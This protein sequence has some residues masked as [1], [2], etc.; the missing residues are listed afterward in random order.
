[1]RLFVAVPAAEGFLEEASLA[2]SLL[3]TAGADVKWVNP[4]CLH[5][6]LH[7]LGEAELAGVPEVVSALDCVKSANPFV[8]RTAGL[9]FFPGSEKPEVVWLGAENTE[10]LAELRTLLAGRLAALGFEI[11]SRLFVPHLTLG[12]VKSP[13]NCAALAEKAGS[14]ACSGAVMT[15][16][17]VVLFESVLKPD[18]PQYRRLGA[19]HLGDEF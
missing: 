6:T 8:M 2:Q 19:A 3:R 15:V 1:V 11:D 16:N 9:G 7:F 17:S 4:E 5:F 13:R 14:L 18:G 12:R 10:P